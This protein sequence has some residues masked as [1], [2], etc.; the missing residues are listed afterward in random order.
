MYSKDGPLHPWATWAIPSLSNEYASE[1][2]KVII[3]W[4]S[5]LE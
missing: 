3:D 4:T 2:A 5:Q 1:R